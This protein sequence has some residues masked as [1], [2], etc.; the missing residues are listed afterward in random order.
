[1]TTLINKIGFAQSVQIDTGPFGS[2]SITDISADLVSADVDLSMD[3]DNGAATVKLRQLNGAIVENVRIYIYFDNF[4]GTPTLI[5]NG[6]VTGI[7][8][9]ADATY[10]LNCQDVMY[11]LRAPWTRDDRTYTAVTEG[12]V[13][14]NLVEASGIDASLTFIVD[15]GW[16]IGVASDV[17]LHGGTTITDTG[18]AGPCDV[19]LDLIRKIDEATPLYRTYT[20][21]N[22]AVYRTQRVVNASG[23][24]LYTDG[25]PGSD[26][27]A[28]NVER[29]RDLGA[30][31]N[32]IKIN[33]ATIADVPI[34]SI[35]QATSAYIPDPPKYQSLEIDSYLIEDQTHADA[36]SAALLAEYNQRLNVVTFTT[37]LDYTLN[38]GTTITVN[39]ATRGLSNVDMLVISVH[40][41]ISGPTATSAATC[42]FREAD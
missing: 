16:T 27:A 28:W 7:S 23:P 9:N 13:V 6:Y 35:A 32:S 18:A 19:P 12:S 22:G 10:T 2:P 25:T 5:F 30:I 15:T 24:I 33:G 42:E 26:N 3:A 29:R 8:W 39:S 11:R 1:M 38:P 4:G 34:E 37:P 36:V 40:H 14:Q 20:R 17:V 41:S 21:G 31:K